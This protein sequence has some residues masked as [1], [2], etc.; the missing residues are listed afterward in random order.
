MLSESG[1]PQTSFFLEGRQIDAGEGFKH[2]G[3]ISGS[4]GEGR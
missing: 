3:Q 1:S 4:E 2:K